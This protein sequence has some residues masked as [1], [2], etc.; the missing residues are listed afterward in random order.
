[1]KNRSFLGIGWAFPT[2]FNMDR[3]S[4][5]LV[6]DEKSICQSIKT[7]LSTT[8]GERIH[9]YDYGCSI[10]QYAFE[11]MDLTTQTIMKEQIERSIVMFEPRIRLNTVSFEM[12][13]N[14]GIMLIHLD[15]TIRQTNSR[16]NMV[17]PFYLYEGTEITR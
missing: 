2:E 13:Q 8:P 10:R 6:S 16:S 14:D 11:I 15:Y 3:S 17:Y 5:S 12:E 1:M 9:R 4:V 7:L